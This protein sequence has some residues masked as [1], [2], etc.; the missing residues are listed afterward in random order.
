MSLKY[1]FILL[2]LC[3]GLNSFSQ[4]EEV[5]IHP[6]KGQ[7]DENILYSIELNQG[8]MFIEKDGFTYAL[9]DLSSHHEESHDE[10]QE[11]HLA[12]I[13]KFHT[14]KTKFKNSSWQGDYEEKD[15][16]YFYRNYFLGQDTN[17]WASKVYAFKLLKLIDFYPAI[18]LIIEMRDEGVKYSFDVAAGADISSIAM[19]HNGADSVTLQNENVH[20]NTRFGP[21]IEKNLA[22]WSQG[23]NGGKS[24][25]N[26]HFKV[27]GNTV[28]F[29]FPEKYD[30][31]KRLII[32]P[33]L[34]FSSFTGANSDNW[35]FTAAPDADANLFGG[36]IIIGASYPT[37]VGAYDVTFNGGEGANSFDIGISKFSA[38]GDAL[39]YST[40]IGG[41]RNETPNSIVSNDAGELFVLG[42]TSSNNFPLAGTPF[43]G[44]FQG[45]PTTTQNGLQ[46]SGTDIVLFKFSP[47]GTN[48]MA[49]TYFG[50]TGNDGLNLGTLNYNYGDQFRGEIIVNGNN[51][52]IASSTQSLDFPTPNGWKNTIS[53]G[54]DAIVAKFTDDLSTALWSTYF[55]GSN[56]ETGNALQISSTGNVFMTGGTNSNSIDIPSGGH[57][58]SFQGGLADG[59]VAAFD[60]N[61]STPLNGTYIGSGGYDQSYFVQLDLDDN[62]YVF[63][64][65]NGNMPISGGVYNNPNS[66]QFIQKYDPTLSIVEWTTRVGGG[67]NTIEIS[68]TAFLVSDCGEI[69]YAG[70]GGFT[71]QSSQASNST[72]NGFP[73]TGD[74]FQSTTTGNNFY[75]AVLGEDATA[76]S[77]AS[78]MGGSVVPNHVDGGTSRFDK[79]GRIYHAVCGGCGGN[80]NGFTTTPGVVSTTNNS[81]NCNMAVFK[82][83]LGI[84]ESSVSTPAPFVCIPDP[85]QFE[86]ES[87][88]ANEYF[89]DF[90]DGNTSNEFEPDHVYSEPG[91][92]TVTLYAT[93]TAGCFD[94]D[95]TIIEINIGLYEGSIT[96]PPLPICPGEPYEL[97]ASGGTNYAWSP[98]EFL[99]DSTKATPL[100]TIFEDTEF[101]VIITDSCGTDTLTVLLEVYGSD[102]ETIDDF[103]ICIDDTVNIWATGAATYEWSPTESIIGSNELAEITVAPESTTLYSVNVTTSEGCELKDEVLVTVFYDVP[104]P[105][106]ADSL[107]VCLGDQLTLTANGAE[108][109]EWSP[110]QYLNT[111]TGPTV[112]TKPTTDITYTV[113]FTNA[114]GTVNDSIFIKVIEVNPL[115]GSDTIVCPG[116]RVFLWAEGGVSYQW[117]PPNTVANPSSS[118]TTA[119]PES[120]TT[121]EVLVTDKNGCSE[122]AAVVIDHFPDPYL[123]IQSDYY[124]FQ[125]EEVELTANGNSPA[126]NYTWEP[127]EFLDCSDCQSPNANPLQTTTFTVFYVDGNGCEA[128]G[129]TTVNL[130]GIIYVP[131]TFTPD[132]SGFNDKF[133]PKGGNILSYHMIIFNRWGEVVFETY[134][135]NSKW[136]GT[137]G[138]E[139]CKDG[140][141]VWKITYTDISNHKK[142]I[143]GHVNLLR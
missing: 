39:L 31:T 58:N 99:D 6:N 72:T 80:A 14:V 110:N 116:E 33:E 47:D 60:A 35:G 63:G 69:Y 108:T 122:T 104:T 62:V 55:G 125:G 86:N 7:W 13:N 34:T 56:L 83:D 54:Q 126:G 5:W 139:K 127:D 96:E 24:T 48:L 109:Y 136:D 9:N 41:A 12:E 36:G 15:T 19:V 37:S 129:E 1:W 42:V 23:D 113:S 121:Y 61:T 25:V 117:T 76:L 89:W 141:Y 29:D 43:Q 40:F 102:F 4:E 92:Y 46:F 137:Y 38:Q 30:T 85:V 70:W 26:A 111:N 67:N 138:G 134:D 75:V 142:E 45:G 53:G 82:F 68:P 18:D 27:R 20:I 123:I 77:Y 17:R 93:D 2:F 118:S 94:G 8:A 74:A 101:T 120:P 66:G 52:Y 128:Q 131:N 143:M 84:I 50:G 106:L 11:R 114:C 78:F 49:S 88:N 64:Q 119:L 133:Y 81:N 44:T 90:G 21:I 105:I 98:A 140:T 57:L 132:D 22:V 107:L 10:N 95:S 87:E 73:V 32:D 51:I 28:Y 130:D 97:E 16:S 3:S 59:Y 91:T 79:K 65:T 100:A 103:S 112:I 135:F 115:A 71:N 124:T